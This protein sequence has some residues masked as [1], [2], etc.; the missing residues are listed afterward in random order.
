MHFKVGRLCVNVVRFCVAFNRTKIFGGN[1][2]K[3]SMNLN[4]WPQHIKLDT[5]NFQLLSLEPSS[6]DCLQAVYPRNLKLILFFRIV[7]Y[8]TCTLD[9][10]FAFVAQEFRWYNRPVQMSRS[11]GDP[12][13]QKLWLPNQGKDGNCQIPS[14][15]QSHLRADQQNQYQSQFIAAGNLSVLAAPNEM[16]YE[17]GTVDAGLLLDETDSVLGILEWK[18]I[19]NMTMFDLCISVSS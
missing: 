19:I 18:F 8:V 12:C 15:S 9:I 11:K 17:T 4:L 1:T 2:S 13:Q 5:W 14:Q 10:F 6:A 16:V 7:Y 3:H